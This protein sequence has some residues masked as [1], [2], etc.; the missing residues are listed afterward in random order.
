[1]PVEDQESEG[2]TPAWRRGSTLSRALSVLLFALMDAA[3]DQTSRIRG[4]FPALTTRTGGS[5]Q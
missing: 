4:A 3:F 2:L 1:M 5:A